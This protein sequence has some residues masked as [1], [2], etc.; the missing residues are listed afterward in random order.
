MAG[1][2]SPRCQKKRKKYHNHQQSLLWRSQ[3]VELNAHRKIPVDIYSPN[4]LSPQHHCKGHYLGYSI[5]Y[6]FGRLSELSPDP[7]VCLGR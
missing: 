6:A 3:G 2:C 5:V 7:I 4:Y 1:K